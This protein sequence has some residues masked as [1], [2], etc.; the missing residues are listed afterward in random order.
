MG[1]ALPLPRPPARHDI[2]KARHGKLRQAKVNARRQARN[3]AVN[4]P[5]AA[6]INR[7]SGRQAPATARPA[8]WGIGGAKVEILTF[9]Q[10]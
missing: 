5:Q 9:K 2:G 4:G 3:P 1:L 7:P 6:A 10:R 8:K